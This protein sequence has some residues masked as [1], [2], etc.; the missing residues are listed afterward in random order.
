MK[1][2]EVLQI[3]HLEWE[4][5]ILKPEKMEECLGWN[6]GAVTLSCEGRKLILDSVRTDYVKEGQTDFVWGRTSVEIDRD[7]FPEDENYTL[8]VEDLKNPN[9]KVEYFFGWE[10][11]SLEED[12]AYDMENIKATL[13]LNGNVE[14][15]QF[16]TELTKTQK[17]I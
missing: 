5:P 10:D 4:V 3:G 16:E 1:L 8:L 15:V 9:L 2:E 13:T 17:E 14:G 7:I 12:D 6:I 11:D